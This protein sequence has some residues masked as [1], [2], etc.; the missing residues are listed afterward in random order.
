MPFKWLVLSEWRLEED[1]TW[2]HVP[3]GDL[4]QML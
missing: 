2:K 1:Y 3:Q 4:V